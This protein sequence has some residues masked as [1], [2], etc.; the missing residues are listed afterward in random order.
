MSTIH[1]VD[2][3]VKNGRSSAYWRSNMFGAY[4]ALLDSTLICIILV[5]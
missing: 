4:L 5:K 3:P 2:G 1:G